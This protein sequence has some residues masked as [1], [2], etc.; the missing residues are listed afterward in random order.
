ME[1]FSASLAFCEGNPLVSGEFPSQK[2][3]DAELWC[4]SLI[5]TLTNSWANN[6]DAGDLRHHRAYYDVTVMWN[7]RHFQNDIC[8]YTGV[9]GMEKN[10]SYL[11]YR[12][13]EVRLLAYWL[14]VTMSMM[15]SLITGVSIDYSIVSLG[16]DQRKHQ[17]S[18]SLAFVRG[19]HRWLVN[20]PHKGPVT[21]KVF[22]FD[23]VIMESCGWWC[24]EPNTLNQLFLLCCPNL[25]H[26]TAHLLDIFKNVPT[27]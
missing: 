18:A 11:L 15:A 26:I 9:V 5:C 16:A 19:I 2:A 10:S 27:Y 3:G 12:V 1:T 25:H 7:G 13:F 6:G 20:S 23:D 22:P 14:D 4:F 24:M 21:P 8:L 17:N